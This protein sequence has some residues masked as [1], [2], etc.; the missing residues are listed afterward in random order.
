LVG[1]IFVKQI[2]IYSRN[3]KELTLMQIS[4]QRLI[5][6]IKEELNMQEPTQAVQNTGIQEVVEKPEIT[7]RENLEEMIKRELMEMLSK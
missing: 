7:S 4:K 3:L 5:E 1:G 2:T 6:I